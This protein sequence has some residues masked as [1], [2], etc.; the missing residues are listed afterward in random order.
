VVLALWLL[1]VLLWRFNFG[2]LLQRQCGHESVSEND[3]AELASLMR[4]CEQHT[5][6]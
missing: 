4:S 5:L 6:D 1:W 2:Y 3:S